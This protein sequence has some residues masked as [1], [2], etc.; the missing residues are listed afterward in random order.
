MAFPGVQPLGYDL[1]G[2][3]FAALSK[4][5][6]LQRKYHWQL[7]IPHMINGVFG[8]II[9]QFCQ[10][11]RIA[12]YS[13]RQLSRMQYGAF[14]RFYAGLQGI[15]SVPLTF[16]VPVDNSVLDYFHGW[17]HL[18]LD[19]QGYYHPASEYKKRLYVALYDKSGVESIRFTLKGAFPVNK[20]T[21]EMTYDAD[22]ILRVGVVLSVDEI[23]TGGLIGSIRAGAMDIVGDVAQQTKELLGDVG[24]TA[25]GVVSKAGNI[26]FG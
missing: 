8:H 21:V 3:G 22:D 11:V 16:V 6:V 24:G 23:E 18:M 4:T 14:Q 12:N 26:L 19:E 20:P 2:M 9:S 17:Y 10:D 13:I 25:H 1:S 7:F 5:W 15:Q